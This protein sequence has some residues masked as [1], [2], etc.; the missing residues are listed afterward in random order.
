[1]PGSE[2][3]RGRRGGW[4]AVLSSLKTRIETRHALPFTMARGSQSKQR[5]AAEKHRGRDGGPWKSLL[6]EANGRLTRRRLPLPPG[7][8]SRCRR[9]G[10]SGTAGIRA[11]R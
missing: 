5:P 6:V 7:V 2:R 8:P 10:R 4:P 9:S 1:M 11:R 3:E